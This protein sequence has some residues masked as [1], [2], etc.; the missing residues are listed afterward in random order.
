MGA[1]TKT[2]AGCGCL[3]ILTAIVL[4]VGLGLGLFWLKD[5]AYDVTDGLRAVTVR[6]SEIDEW[7]RRANAHPYERRADGVVPEARLKAFLEVRRRVYE[8]Y[9]GY[10]DEINALRAQAEGRRSPPSSSELLALGARAVEMFSDLRLAQVQALAEVEMSEAEY[11]AIQTA[12]YLAAGASKA[13]SETGHLPAEAPPEA[14]RQAQEALRTALEAAREKGLPGTGGIT[15]SD[16]TA[17]EAALTKA[18]ASGAEALAVPPANVKL[19]RRYEA[20]IR[21]YAM[22]GLTVLG[23]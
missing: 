21:R 14:A 12:V 6:T 11:Y 10:R 2:L 13:D 16:L 23:L 1:G 20:D 19:F 4:V 8:V 15:E 3:A 17:L 5:R 22:H 18:G 9:R 7:E